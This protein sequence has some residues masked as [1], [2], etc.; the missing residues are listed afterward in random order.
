V[1]FGG[2]AG[3][4]GTATA[5]SSGV[6]NASV[7]ATVAGSGLTVTVDDGSGH[8]GSAVIT[9][10]NPGPLDHFAISPISS[11]QAA[12]TAFAIRIAAQDADNNTATSFGGTVTF[13]GT[14]GVTGP[15]AAFSSGVLN[16]SVTPTVAGSGL[17]VTV[18]DGSGHTGLA[19]IAGVNPGTIAAG[20]TT[21]GPGGNYPWALNQAS[22]GQGTSPGWV[23]LNISGTLTVSATAGDPF[24]IQVTSLLL[25]DKAGPVHDFNLEQSYVWTLATA[26][27]G[28]HG[29]DATKFS[30]DAS[31]FEN[32]TGGGTFSVAQSGNSVNLLFTP[33]ACNPSD[34]ILNYAIIGGQAQLYFTNRYGLSAVEGINLD[35]CTMTGTAYGLGFPG[36][37]SVGSI[38]LDHTLSLPSG[39]TNLVIIAARINP[40]AAIVN[41]G[42][43][44]ECNNYK[45][46]DPLIAKLIAQ[47]GAS[48]WQTYSGVPSAEHYVALANGTPGLR[49]VKLLVNGW[50]YNLGALAD[51]Q[52]VVVDVGASMNPGAGNTIL[53]MAGGGQ[54]AT[55]NILIADAP[56]GPLLPVQP[57]V[58]APVLS[59]VQEGGSVVLSWPAPAGFFT[60]Q[61][62]A[63]LDPD[64]GWLD[65]AVNQQGS[66]GLSFVTI[67]G[68]ASCQLFR[69]RK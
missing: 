6:R 8:T 33:H 48:V 27:G 23:L 69:L 57:Q 1:R 42:V 64:T 62:R 14:A 11:P 44:D 13:A 29:F 19:V 52:A 34:T 31:G 41:A 32:F 46:F 36:G 22:S 16:A 60:L 20:D 17:T 2:T 51:G 12:G 24:V 25:G 63:S 55:A 26:S 65:L 43:Y 18:T 40:G 53:V 49:S 37:I 21:W 30:I 45:Q 68:Q 50:T 61:G 58:E 56:S 9:L 4:T 3:V 15:S 10:V 54:G 5:F 35:N 38:T 7:T 39:T 59:F 28:I 47:A 66:Q 67:Q